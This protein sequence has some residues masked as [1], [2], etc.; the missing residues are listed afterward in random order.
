MLDEYEENGKRLVEKMNARHNDEK[1]MAAVAQ[2]QLTVELFT[3]FSFAGREIAGHL[4]KLQKVQ[5]DEAVKTLLHPTLLPQIEVLG[6]VYQETLRTSSDHNLMDRDTQ[7]DELMSEMAGAQDT[8]DDLAD[9]MF[10]ELV[11]D[12]EYR[13]EK[14]VKA[15]EMLH[16]QADEFLKNPLPR[17]SEEVEFLYEQAKENPDPTTGSSM[18]KEQAVDDGLGAA[19]ESDSSLEKSTDLFSPDESSLDD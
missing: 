15:R 10:E 7:D 8:D 6:K 2:Q 13:D 14:A 5:V 9:T 12:A 16:A 18:A 1:T 11:R 19:D 3:K 17:G 4:A